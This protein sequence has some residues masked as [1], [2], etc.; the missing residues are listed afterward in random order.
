MKKDGL[1][2]PQRTDKI[3]LESAIKKDNFFMRVLEQVQD[4]IGYKQKKVEEEEEG[5]LRDE[6]EEYG[7]EKKQ[8]SRKGKRSKGKKK[9]HIHKRGD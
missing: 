2:M 1:Y 7:H 8:K 3:M 5:E 9:A 4:K 6:D